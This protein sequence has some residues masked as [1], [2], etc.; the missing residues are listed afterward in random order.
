MSTSSAHADSEKKTFAAA[1]PKWTLKCFPKKKK[2]KRTENEQ[3][4]ELEQNNRK[5]KQTG[6]V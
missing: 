6:H 4:R 1:K 2:K 5:A 3:K